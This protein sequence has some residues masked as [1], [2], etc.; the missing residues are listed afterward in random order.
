MP[1]SSACAYFG[2]ATPPTV[3]DSQLNPLHARMLD[4]AGVVSEA[5]FDSC[6]L[7]QSQNP[8]L[9]LIARL[10]D[11]QLFASVRASAIQFYSVRSCDRPANPPPE[12]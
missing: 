11:Q 8:S 12:G 5:A 10:G 6:A 3:W 7:R 1:I 4:G 9:R 2:G